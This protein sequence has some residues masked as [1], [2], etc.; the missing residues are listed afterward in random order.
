M[1]SDGV[2]GAII[3]NKKEP[4]PKFRFFFVWKNFPHEDHGW[5][6]KPEK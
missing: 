2:R 5:T 6:Y 4:N 3:P 1:H